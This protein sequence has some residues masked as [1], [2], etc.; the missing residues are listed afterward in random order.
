MIVIAQ[1]LGLFSF[2]HKS[3]M[4][5]NL[6]REVIAQYLGLFSF[7]H[8]S[9]ITRACMVY[10]YSPVSRALLI[11]TLTLKKAHIYALFFRYNSR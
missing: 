2:S 11:F 8:K 1:Y 7:S 5:Q 3:L 4:K 9:T 6:E 10:G